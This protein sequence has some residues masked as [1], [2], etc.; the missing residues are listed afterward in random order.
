MVRYG[1]FINDLIN[2]FN[3][4]F[5]FPCSLLG[6]CIYH[7]TYIKLCLTNNGVNRS[8]L[9]IPFLKIVPCGEN[10]LSSL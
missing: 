1:L 3:I 10:T 8:M 5:P 4:V 9:N 7:L 2:S 6:S